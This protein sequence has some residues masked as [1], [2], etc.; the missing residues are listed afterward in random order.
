MRLYEVFNCY[1]V[2]PR[3]CYEGCVLDVGAGDL[4]AQLYSRHKDIIQEGL[5]NQTY[6]PI[7]LPIDIREYEPSIKFD[8]ILCLLMI[9][10]IPKED[11]GDL[12]SNFK[13]WLRPN[14]RLVI[15]EAYNRS[16]RNTVNSHHR[17]FDITQ[18]TFSQYL[19]NATYRIMQSGRRFL[20]RQGWGHMLRGLFSRGKYRGI[21]WRGT[22]T[23]FVLWTKK[24]REA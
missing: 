14:G 8:T 24:E 3:S 21:Y 6:T 4:S 16:K 11:W 12:I 7:D 9:A 15:A 2:V 17:T 18:D 22:K 20:P 19:T 1:D 5:K 23:L 13:N 10:Y